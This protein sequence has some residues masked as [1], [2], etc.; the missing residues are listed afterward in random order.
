[1]IFKYICLLKYS[2]LYIFYY[3]V[4]G[5]CKHVFKNL[6]GHLIILGI[7]LKRQQ[8]DIDV[9]TSERYKRS[10]FESCLSDKN[11]YRIYEVNHTHLICLKMC[12]F[13]C[14]LYLILKIAPKS[15]RR[16]PY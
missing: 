3:F 11:T 4:T 12:V 6:Y 7:M 8:H 1:M 9:L 16:L 10:T 15:F 13:V 2:V 5:S 14:M